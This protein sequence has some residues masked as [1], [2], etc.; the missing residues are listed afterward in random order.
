MRRRN[1]NSICISQSACFLSCLPSSVFFVVSKK[2]CS[3]AIWLARLFKP[4]NK[5]TLLFRL[6][7]TWREALQR[8]HW[9]RRWESPGSGEHIC[10]LFI[11]PAQRLFNFSL[12]EKAVLISLI[13]GVDFY[14]LESLFLVLLLWKILGG[15]RRLWEWQ[16]R[17]NLVHTALLGAASFHATAEIDA[18]FLLLQN[19]KQ[20]LWCARPGLC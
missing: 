13:T 6:L 17:E 11:S 20:Q 9:S 14:L 15:S 19:L 12:V 1:V 2:F 5:T 10:H 4:P 16:G 7:E 8:K 3:S 18:V